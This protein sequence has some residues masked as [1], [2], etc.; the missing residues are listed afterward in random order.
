MSDKDSQGRTDLQSPVTLLDHIGIEIQYAVKQDLM[1]G[2]QSMP[3]R[4]G[5]Y[6]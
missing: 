3:S 6:M 1:F 4:L 2:T 5:V